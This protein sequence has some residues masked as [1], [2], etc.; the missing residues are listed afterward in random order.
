MYVLE[1]LLE[2]ASALT[3]KWHPPSAKGEVSVG[4]SC[5]CA[6]LATAAV[7]AKGPY[8]RTQHC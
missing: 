7:I 3:Y 5:I 2:M 1:I 4:K 8:K 6:V